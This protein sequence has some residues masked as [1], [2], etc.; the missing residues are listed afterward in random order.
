M[1]AG[2]VFGVIALLV[3]YKSLIVVP[4]QQR[5][6]ISRLGR[7]R[8]VAE[9]G[10]VVVIPLIDAIAARYSLE[11]Q[12]VRIPY[13]GGELVVNYR[14]V[15]PEKVF[16]GLADVTSAVHQSAQTAI[17]GMSENPIT[18][19]FARKALAQKIDSIVDNFG[20]KVIDVQ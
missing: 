20:L 11:Q 10:L 9:P 14:V 16:H 13:K 7:F 4:A 8:A 5:F 12:Q 3:V 17:N 1:T 18:D 6:V 15:D 19:V 2:I